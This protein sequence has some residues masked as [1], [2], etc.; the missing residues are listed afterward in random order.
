MFSQKRMYRDIRFLWTE[1]STA[2]KRVRKT[3][4]VFK[5]W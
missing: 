3:D 2:F 4:L 5:K 1:V